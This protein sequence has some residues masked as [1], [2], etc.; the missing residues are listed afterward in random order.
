MV[1]FGRSA[2]P[3]PLSSAIYRAIPFGPE[4]RADRQMDRGTWTRNARRTTMCESP[5]ARSLT[6]SDPRSRVQNL[7]SS[8]GRLVEESIKGK[9][10]RLR[11][12]R[13]RRCSGCGGGEVLI[14]IV[15][16]TQCVW[17][18]PAAHRTGS[19]NGSMRRRRSVRV[20]H[21]GHRDRGWSNALS[22]HL[23]LSARS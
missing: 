4:C 3:D 9:D 22:L 23:I 8:V 12:G 7:L 17:W 19:T 16:N 10:S 18:P 20:L 6:H 14:G 13:R 2:L 21:H 11:S 15:V 1:L 5:L